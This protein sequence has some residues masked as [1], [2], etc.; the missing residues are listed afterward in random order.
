MR[1]TVLAIALGATAVAGLVVIDTAMLAAGQFDALN[2]LSSC[3]RTEV[4]V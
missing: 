1:R 4:V 2:P 3:R